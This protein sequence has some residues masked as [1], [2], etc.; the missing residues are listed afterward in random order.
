MAL[1]FPAGTPGATYVGGNGVTYTFDATA[2]VWTAAASGGGAVFPV[3]GPAFRAT[4]GTGGQSISNASFTKVTL[5]TEIFDTA[6]CY[7]TTTSRFTPTLAGYYQVNGVGTVSTAATVAFILIG[8][9]K[10]GVLYSIGGQSSGASQGPG[11]GAGA[12]VSDLVYLNGTT[13]YIE[14]YA[15][16]NQGGAATFT[17][18]PYTHFSA[19]FVRPT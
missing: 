8:I 4:S 7:D 10:N 16:T 15:Y 12:L 3:N 11:Q 9:Y 13:D 1:Q 2:G 17:G 14:L 6:T 19:A 5:A 18:A